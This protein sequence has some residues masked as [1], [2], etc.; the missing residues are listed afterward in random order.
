MNKEPLGN[1]G[2]YKEILNGISKYKDLKAQ[3]EQGNVYDIGDM[4]ITQSAVFLDIHPEDKTDKQS[5][6]SL[7]YVNDYTDILNGVSNFRGFCALDEKNKKYR[8][9]DV[10]ITSKGV[11]LDIFGDDE[12]AK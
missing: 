9:G 12:R 1:L 5:P 10:H 7:G 11:F 6:H 3:D 8:I 4:H 2:V